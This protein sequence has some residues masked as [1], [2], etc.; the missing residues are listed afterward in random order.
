MFTTAAIIIFT[1]AIARLESRIVDISPYQYV[2]ANTF[3]QLDCDVDIDDVDV[4]QEDILEFVWSREVD[5]DTLEDVA[6]IMVNGVLEEGGVGDVDEGYKSFL[7]PTDGVLRWSLIIENISADQAGRWY[8][9][10]I[11]DGQALWRRVSMVGVGAG[12]GVEH[13]MMFNIDKR[14]GE[15]TLD[16]TDIEEGSTKLTAQD[17][18]K[19]IKVDREDSGIYFCSVDDNGYKARSTR[20]LSGHVPE[21]Q[22]GNTLSHVYQ[23]PGY[24][25]TVTCEVVAA[26]A[27]M[28][29]WWRVTNDS[30]VTRLRSD[31]HLDVVISGYRDGVVSSSVSIDSVTSEHYGQYVCEASNLHGVTNST[32]HLIF[33]GQPVLHS[34]ES[35]AAA[36]VCTRVWTAVIS[37]TIIL[38]S[39]LNW[40]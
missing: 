39:L 20:H 28:I 12:D 17:R 37:Q 4:S 9:E 40:L 24:P 10:V 25:A 23:H 35:S 19:M 8:C 38:M 30:D 7:I 21:I 34:E 36:S 5:V 27:P 11:R 3:V 33:S 18:D 6:A 29:S 2:G 13:N 14:G 32:F 26:P 1:S 22:T 15:V 31:D 16:C